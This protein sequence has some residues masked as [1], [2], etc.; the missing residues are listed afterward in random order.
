MLN[1]FL[2]HNKWFKGDIVIIHDFLP[3]KCRSLLDCYRNITYQQVSDELK[4]KTAVLSC[5][6]PRLKLE[7][8]LAR[9]HSLELFRL[10]ENRYHKVL[11]CDSDILFLGDVKEIFQLEENFYCC[12]DKYYYA[13]NTICSNSYT[14]VIGS[15]SDVN[16]HDVLKSTFNAGFMLLDKALI[17]KN[18][19]NKVLNL[20][21]K[22]IW[23]NIQAPY[24]D[25][26]I[27]N[28][29]FRGQ[30]IVLTSK[31]NFLV[32]HKEL[33]VTKERI[34]I[35]DIKVLHFNGRTKPWDY[36]KVIEAISAD[37]S[38]MEF[39]KLWQQAYLDFLPEFNLR[40]NF[41]N[42]RSRLKKK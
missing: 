31:Y 14:P 36:V 9:F 33:I 24:T 15:L 7:K 5:S 4:N 37:S 21:N 12:G 16:D 18:H 25:Q 10:Y 26:I 2:K 38:N 28:L 22:N 40:Y 11:F 20:L 17:T 32:L 35:K 41:R 29:Y 27:F 6:V 42:N 3:D 23:H 39:F 1:S 19:Y 34:S 8:K 13:N 30:H